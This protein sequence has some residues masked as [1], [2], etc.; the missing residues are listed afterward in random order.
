MLILLGLAQLAFHLATMLLLI[1]GGVIVAVLLRAIADPLRERFGW[2]ERVAVLAALV[3]VLTLMGVAG[4]LFGHEAVAQSAELVD[5]L[6]DAWRALQARIGGLPF[7]D[8]L[9]DQLQETGAYI[10]RAVELAPKVALGTASALTNLLLVTVGGVMLAMRPGSY[11]NGVSTLFPDPLSERVRPAM[12][13]AGHA[14]RKWLVAQF[15]SMLVIGVL[16]GTGL[17]IAGVPSPFALGLFAGVAQFVPVVGPAV[18]SI[19]GLLLGA[20]QGT[21]SFLWAAAVYF[22]VQQL[23]SNLVTPFVQ[24]RLASVPMA[25]TLFAVIGFGVLLGPLGVLFATPL[26]VVA[27]SLV[28]SLYLGDWLGRSGEDAERGAASP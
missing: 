23:E 16:T 24:K 9:L 11:R 21:E 7:G 25:M 14:L 27:Y 17:W 13:E 6:P 26:L 28:R 18:S 4:W 19:P 12:D 10:S 3:L 8:R 22:G 20:S 1:F 2:D 5:Q 15:I